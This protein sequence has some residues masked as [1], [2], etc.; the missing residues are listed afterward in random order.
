MV[1]ERKSRFGISPVD[2]E[3]AEL[4]R[5][6]S[7]PMS[8]AVREAAENLS[9]ATEAKVEARRKNAED[10]KFLR[11][12][13]EDGLIIERISVEDIRTDGLPRDRIDLAGVAASD[14]MDELKTSIRAYGQREP[15][16]LYRDADGAL[17]LKKGWRRL[18]AL[19]SLLEE[20]GE[21]RFSFA[22]ARVDRS[23]PDRIQNYVDMVEENVIRENLS[24]AEMAQVAISAARDPGVEGVDAEVHVQRLYG[25][26]H[27]M[28]RSYIRSFVRLLLALGDDL[29]FPKAV[30][31]NLGVEVERGLADGRIDVK[32][33]RAS[34]GLCAD[35]GAQAEV[36]QFSVVKKVSL[37]PGARAEAVGNV[38]KYEFRLGDLKVTARK[39][40]LRVKADIDYSEVPRDRLEKAIDALRRALRDDR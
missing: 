8:A 34:L 3:P 29:K 22:L 19:R 36:L 15:V 4:R 37:P 32:A 26:L 39:G 28:K 40:E 13:R 24:F 21:D 20:T 30:S 31:R 25:S 5:R 1:E 12:A 27:K 10:A 14:E 23:A 2:I 11:S 7:G 38:R 6:G 33:L 16:E 17:Q 18:T 35:P 9:E